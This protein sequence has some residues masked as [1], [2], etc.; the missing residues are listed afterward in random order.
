MAEKY[1]WLNIETGMFTNS[2]NEEA[3]NA[4]GGLNELLEDSKNH[5]GWKLIKYECLNDEEF[6]FNRLM[7]LR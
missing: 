4:A 5:F 6:D 3:L 2:W 1:V 7:K